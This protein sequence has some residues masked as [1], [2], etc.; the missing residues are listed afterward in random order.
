MAKT[1]PQLT[2]ATT[3]NAADELIVQQGG[4][5]KRAT[6]AE[7]GQGLTPLVNAANGIVNVRDF[8]ATGDGVTDDRAAFVQANAAGGTLF[9]PKPLVSYK[10]SSPLLLD[11][12]AVVAD[13]AATWNQLTD[14]GNLTWKRGNI[15]TAARYRFADRV[16]IGSAASEVAGNSPSSDAGS[17]WYANLVD[18]PGY[19]GINAQVLAAG[20]NLYKYVG[21]TRTSE[22]PASSMVFGAQV[23]SDTADRTCWGGVVEIQRTAG[24]VYGWEIAAKNKGA[25]HIMTPNLK[26]QGVY[27]LW[28]ASGGDNLFGG[29]ATNPSTAAVVILKNDDQTWNSGIVFQRDALTS[30]EAIAFSSAGVGGSHRQSWYNESG[31]IVFTLTSDATD[32]VGWLL[33]RRNNGL[34]VIVAGK[35][36]FQFSAPE[37]SVNGIAFSSS[38]ASSSP[39]ISAAGEDENLDIRLSP[40]GTGNVRYGTHAAVTTET[41]SGF[42]TIKDSAGNTRKLAV[43]S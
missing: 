5:T 29:G 21:A 1:I 19:M 23:I 10:F 2:D 6:A 27:G 30:G 28:L 8:G 9:L 4:I 35:Q 33:S 16:F 26:P 11:N 39:S 38:V 32:A 37:N 41:L 36:L 20:G 3:V 31:N 24:M 13:P 43:V 7:L 22:H 18:F 14:N 40:K 42:I 12:V 25:N 15:T 17:A 34:N